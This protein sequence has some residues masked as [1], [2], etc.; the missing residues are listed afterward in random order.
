MKK[1]V[2]YIIIS[3]GGLVLTVSCDDEFLSPKPVNYLSEEDVFKSKEAIEAHL[4]RLYWR[5]PMEDFNWPS[6]SA[7]FS[8]HTDEMVNCTQDQNGYNPGNYQWWGEGYKAIRYMNN[9]I[10]KLPESTVYSDEREKED[11]LG[12]VYWLRAYTYMALARRYGGV[13]ILTKVQELTEDPTEL[14]IPRYTEEQVFDLVLSDLDIAISKLSDNTSP[15]K[16]NKWTAIAFKSRVMLY[17]A[18]LARYSDKVYDG[19]LYMDGLLGIPVGKATQYYTEAKNAALQIIQ[20]GRY[21]L[22]DYEGDTY[23][24]KI[25]NYEKLFFD[26]SSTNKERMLIR[27]YNFPDRTHRFDERVT[28]F[29]F[30]A[31]SGYSSRRCPPLA[32]VEKFEYVDERDGSI[33]HNGKQLSE[34]ESYPIIVANPN[35]LFE[36]KDP[37]FIHNI[38]YPGSAWRK[39]KVEVYVATTRNGETIPAQGKDGIGQPEATST[40]FYF[41]K[42]LQRKPVRAFNEGSDVDWQIIRYAEVILN[43]AEACFELGETGQALAYVNEIRKRAG[44]QELTTITREDVRNEFAI[45]FYGE[46]NR[47]WDLKRWRT[48]HDVLNNTETYA[49]WPTYNEDKQEYSFVKRQLPSAKFKKTFEPKHYYMGIPQGEIEKNPLLIQNFGH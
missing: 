29:S 35:E 17:A 27:A 1:I 6:S 47:Y 26:E 16:I 23:D 37:R 44:I 22:Y 18:S 49:I 4:A 19:G 5:C 38:L 40:G 3:L 31:G 45:E 25:I 48:F 10:E 7:G 11:V 21:E 14:Q 20:S 32:M 2:L 42:W 46:G 24:A 30:R 33:R 8:L 15:Y 41:A 13:P 9:F 39:D 43:Y 12:Q 36:K 28:P 34:D